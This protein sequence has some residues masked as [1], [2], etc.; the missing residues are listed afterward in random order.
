M[1]YSPDIPTA[2]AAGTCPGD[3]SLQATSRGPRTDDA[4]LANYYARI[5]SEETVKCLVSSVLFFLVLLAF[6]LVALLMNPEM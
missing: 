3:G 4:S 2:S 5:E 6:F 1:M